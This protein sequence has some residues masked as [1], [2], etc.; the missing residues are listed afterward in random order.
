MEAWARPSGARGSR[1]SSGS[2]PPRPSAPRASSGRRRAAL[3]LV[4]VVDRLEEA[5]EPRHEVA[6]GLGAA[7]SGRSPRA[8]R[9][10]PRPTAGTSPSISPPA[11]RPRSRRCRAGWRSRATLSRLA[12]PTPRGGVLMTRSSEVSSRGFTAS[13]R[14]ATTSRT[15]LRSKNDM[16]PTTHVGEPVGPQ[17]RL[18]RPELHLRA[19]QDRR[20]PTASPRP[21]RRSLRISPTTNC[22]SDVSSFEPEGAHGLAVAPRRLERLVVARGVVADDG[23]RRVEDGPGRAVVRLE[24]DDLGPREVAGEVQDL[25]DVGPAPAVDRL[26]VVAHHAD[27]AVLAADL[28]DDLVL[29]RGSCPGTR[30]RGRGGSACG[31]AS[32]TSGC[33]RKQAHG[34]EEEVVEVEGARARRGTRGSA[35]RP[36]PPAGPGRPSPLSR[37]DSGVSI[38]FLASEIRARTAEGCIVVS[39]TRSSRMAD[40]TA[41]SWSEASQIVN[42]RE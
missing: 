26:V 32:R 38:R 30:P 37:N 39:W 31:S 11:R 3:D 12:L 23:V 8:A 4:P 5:P 25:A 21:G 35:A 34:L 14:K 1:R 16:P 29:R 10:S 36:S 41:L 42:R 13:L 40:F 6:A 15:S 24:P 9:G 19:A 22:A 33:S 17:L 27:V 28:A 7:P 2:P 18:E 20:S